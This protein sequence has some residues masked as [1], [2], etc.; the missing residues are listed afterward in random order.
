LTSRSQNFAIAVEMIFK[1]GSDIMRIILS[2]F[3][4]ILV[5]RQAGKEALAAFQPS[6]KSISSDEEVEVDFSGVITFSPSW[7]DEFLTPLHT[8]YGDRLI[9]INIGNNPS[10]Q[11]TLK[12]LEEI[13]RTS[14]RVR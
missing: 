9:L 10:V 3:S 6:L 11:E 13:S 14:F 7:G 4:D 1:M 2:K 8:Q 12:I 5:S